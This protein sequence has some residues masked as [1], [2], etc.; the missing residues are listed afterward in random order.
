MDNVIAQALF[1]C[2]RRTRVIALQGEPMPSRRLHISV[3]LTERCRRHEAGIRVCGS[4]GGPLDGPPHPYAELAQV[5][6]PRAQQFKAMGLISAYFDE[7]G[8]DGQLG[9]T[10]LAGF[11][12]TEAQWT[13]LE[14]AW[15]AARDTFG[16]KTFHM[17]ECFQGIGEFAHLGSLR[18]DLLFKVARIIGDSGVRAVFCGVVDEDW[19]K[20]VTD[21]GF[22]RKYP[23]PLDLCF[24]DIVLQMRGLGQAN[25][26]HERPAL[27]FAHTPEYYARMA[28][29]ARVYAHSPWHSAY[30]G[31]IT[32]S[33]P[34]ELIPL[35]AADF[36]AHEMRFYIDRLEYGP[37]IT[38]RDSGLRQILADATPRG[39]IGHWYEERGLHHMIDRF[40]KTG[41]IL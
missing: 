16:F 32:F 29:I 28:E 34:E 9:V 23:K 18:H 40:K 41:R 5:V 22:L 35:Q 26:H 39:T 2:K 15:N 11:V 21:A 8:T 3:W 20:V 10:V 7:S 36:I 1:R 31:S 17:F 19:R 33:T 38:L 25:P 14:K 12:G 6:H 30:L 37:P 13:T 24:E 4:V 27:V